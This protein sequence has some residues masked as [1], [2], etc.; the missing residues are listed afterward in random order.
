MTIH[1]GSTVVTNI[2]LNI[3]HHEFLFKVNQGVLF[4]FIF[5]FF[6]PN[7]IGMR[8]WL[9]LNQDVWVHSLNTGYKRVRLF[10]LPAETVRHIWLPP[11]LSLISCFLPRLSSTKKWL[12]VE[13]V[14]VILLPAESLN[15]KL[16]RMDSLCRKLFTKHNSLSRKQEITDSLGGSQI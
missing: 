1:G 3:H 15:R 7:N 14:C 11:R 6:F 8:C 4:F 9:N 12:P 10:S 2:D 16:Y 5:I 13:T